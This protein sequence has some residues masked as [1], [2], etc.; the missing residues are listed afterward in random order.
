MWKQRYSEDLPV[1]E[2]AILGGGLANFRRDDGR[3][4]AAKN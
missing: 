3:P 2:G 4:D 1:S